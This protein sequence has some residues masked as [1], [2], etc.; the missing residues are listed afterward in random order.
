AIERG[1][2][3]LVGLVGLGVP[4]ARAGVEVVGH[5]PPEVAGPGLY[6]HDYAISEIRRLAEADGVREGD[7]AKSAWPGDPGEEALPLGLDAV[8]RRLEGA[9]CPVQDLR[10]ADA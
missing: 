7:A 2:R 4:P 1:H 3:D 5:G 10:R 8:V 9:P 6:G